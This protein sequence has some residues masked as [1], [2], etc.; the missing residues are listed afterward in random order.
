VLPKKKKEFT[1]HVHK[2]THSKA[3]SRA[4]LLQCS[5]KLDGLNQL[6]HNTFI[7]GAVAQAYN[8][9]YLGGTD[10]ED[11]SLRSALAKSLKDPI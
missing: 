7:L 10:Q 9:S 8:L 6:K 3:L 2:N 4:S 11:G 5:N 1:L